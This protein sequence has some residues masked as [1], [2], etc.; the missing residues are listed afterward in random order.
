MAM[1]T[2]I[3]ELICKVLQMLAKEYQPDTELLA[4]IK[5]KIF[6]EEMEADTNGQE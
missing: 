1:I 5:I 2:D 6:S 4:R 3:D